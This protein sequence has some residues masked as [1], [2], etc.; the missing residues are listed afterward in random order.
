M[1]GGSSTAVKILGTALAGAMGDTTDQIISNG[2][3]DVVRTIRSG[4]MSA[5]TAAAGAVISKAVSSTAGRTLYNSKGDASPGEAQKKSAKPKVE[6]K[7]EPAKLVQQGKTAAIGKMA[8]L[9]RPGALNGNQFKV[10]DYLPDMGTPKAN[11]HQNSGILRSIM[12]LNQPIY[13]V[14]P[15]PMSMSKAGFLGL[16]RNLLQNNGW[17]YSNGYWYPS[18]R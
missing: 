3:V 2:K 5:A 1:T 6:I 4:L 14:S 17:T 16:E 9:N 12:R 15:Y 10:A 11:W 8:D 7:T 13:D 18:A